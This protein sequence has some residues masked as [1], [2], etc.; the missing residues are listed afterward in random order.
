MSSLG[1][2][3]DLMGLGFS[4][5]VFS[6]GLYFSSEIVRDIFSK[7]EFD[8][9]IDWMDEVFPAGTI[10][11]MKIFAKRYSLICG[12]VAVACAHVGLI[13]AV[14]GMFLECAGY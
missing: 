9:W 2:S 14:V 8:D 13:V 1:V 3:F 12:W 5:L 11:R 10:D 6:V 4:F 7:P